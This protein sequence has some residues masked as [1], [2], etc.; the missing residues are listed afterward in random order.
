MSC[1]FQ[2]ADGPGTDNDPAVCIWTDWLL[3]SGET[4]ED[5][6]SN[7]HCWRER[8]RRRVVCAPTEKQSQR[9]RVPSLP[10]ADWT[11]YIEQERE[12]EK[13]QVVK[14]CGVLC[15]VGAL[16]SVMVVSAKCSKHTQY[17]NKRKQ[18]LQ[19]GIPQKALET[20]YINKPEMKKNTKM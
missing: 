20:L 14:D 18:L 17:N 15:V 6:Q 4:I 9:N 8:E 19:S 3:K 5:I 7:V 12:S 16:H 2:Y 10:R 1:H 13:M 11:V